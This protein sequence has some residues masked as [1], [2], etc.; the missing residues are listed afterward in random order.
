M[1]APKFLF[2]LGSLGAVLALVSL[3]SVARG[4]ASD[5][6]AAGDC[7]ATVTLGPAPD[8]KSTLE[9]NPNCTSGCTGIVFTYTII[10]SHGQPVTITA[11]RCGCGNNPATECCQ[12]VLTPPSSA[13]GPLPYGNCGTPGCPAG[14][15]CAAVGTLQPD[16]GFIFDSAC[17]K[18]AQ[19]EPV[20][21]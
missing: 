8:Y 10:N 9:C 17:K 2:A 11:A 7:H 6:V 19:V 3:A 12:V 21:Q 16:G 15:R 20:G 14:V 5:S 1:I 4:S 18:A 13:G